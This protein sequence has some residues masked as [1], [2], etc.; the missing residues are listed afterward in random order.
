MSSPSSKKLLVILG[1]TGQ[2]GSSVAKLFLSDPALSTTW[3]L[4]GITR[5]PSKP[6]NKHLLDAGV[7]LISG[8]LDNVASLRAAF[9]NADAI[10]A[11]TDFWQ[12]VQA[13]Q[14]PLTFLE[15]EKRGVAPNVVAMEKEEIQGRNIIDAAAAA[16]AEKP[17]HR[18]VVSTLSD[19]KKWSG[20]EI[21]TNL[22][23]DGK[24]HYCEYL[25]A[26][27]PS[28][29][30]VTSY[31]QVGY[32]L[33]N[34]FMS[35]F[36]APHKDPDNPLE[37]IIPH[38]SVPEPRYPVPFVNP[39]HD[40][41][42]FVEALIN[43]APPGTD[44]LGYC[45]AMA[46]EGFA[47]DWGKALGLK[48]RCERFDEKNLVEMGLSEWLAKEVF[49]SGTYVTKWGWAGGDANVKTPEEC[50]VDMSKL[51]DVGEWVKAQNWKL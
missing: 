24:A 43:R 19:S 10:F 11:V 37:Y 2:Q 49:A 44:M 48:A 47:E 5:N 46:F 29:A 21:T 38:G 13:E 33:A 17:L 32:Y 6:S 26:T 45:K 35:P 12:F 50:G 51:T 15:A 22:H 36:W 18:L 9:K 23:F 41:G 16:H 8:D 42:Y 34:C 39:P 3:F 30:K 27:Y 40:V 4:R 25:K 7:E 14:H 1:I 20:G 31:V 28:L